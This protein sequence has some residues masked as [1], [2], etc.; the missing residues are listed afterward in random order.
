MGGRSIYVLKAFNLLLNEAEMAAAGVATS[1]LRF[2][3]GRHD[4][5]PDV[6]A[7]HPQVQVHCGTDA[8]LSD[9]IAAP[10]GSTVDMAPR[11][12]LEAARAEAADLRAQVDDLTMSN[13]SPITAWSTS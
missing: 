13:F 9:V 12:D 7:S 5:V 2:N 10:T 11:A 3:I 6:I 8:Q 4:E 1:L